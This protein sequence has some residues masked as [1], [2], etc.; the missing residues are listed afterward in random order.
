VN[1]VTT[2]PPRVREVPV[3]KDEENPDV[4]QALT[5]LTRE[6]FGYDEAAW[7]K[8]YNTEHNL[9]QFPNT[10]KPPRTRP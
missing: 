9:K 7:R 3:E 8:W 5:L 4:L 10:R 6:D 2:T 1:Q